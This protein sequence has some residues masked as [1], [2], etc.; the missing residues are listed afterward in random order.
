M[1]H[2]VT[3]DSHG[4]S[5]LVERLKSF[6]AE[7]RTSGRGRYVGFGNALINDRIVKSSP[8]LM[9]KMLR[10]HGSLV[11][12]ELPFSASRI[13]VA[14][15]ARIFG[16]KAGN[17]IVTAKL[18][19][20]AGSGNALASRR[21]GRTLFAEIHARRLA[22]PAFKETSGVL[23]TPK[24]VA[25][26]RVSGRWLVEEF[27][28]GTEGTPGDIAHTLDRVDLAKL[29]QSA[30][31]LKP[32]FRRRGIRR[33]SE[34]LETFDPSFPKPAADSVWPEALCHTDLAG[35][36]LRLADGRLC[37]LDWELAKPFPVA[38]DLA[39]VYLLLPERLGSIVEILRAL[40]PSGRALAPQSQLALGL[41]RMI[42]GVVRNP[43][44]H[45]ASI[46]TATGVKQPEALEL[47]RAHLEGFRG[48]LA[49]LRAHL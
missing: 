7:Y 4:L 25:Y 14:T 39:S 43:S 15:N 33:W 17:D 36:I 31:R 22:E 16:L 48:A 9:H 42:A 12:T 32:V 1:F 20:R 3:L 11:R 10:T 47:H 18:L 2:R 45:I 30:A 23:F 29:Y 46:M 8:E 21:E 19:M 41:M 37:I 26:D 13:E 28:E 27:V 49:R 38:G 40:D 24:I 34:T 44:A 6:A 35:N 5:R